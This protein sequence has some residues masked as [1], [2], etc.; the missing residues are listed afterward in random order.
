MP[1][2][3]MKGIILSGGLG[4]RL[5]PLTKVV[6]K[7]L[8][9]VYDKPMVYY[10]LTTLINA[11]IKEIAL[12]STPSA[13]PMFKEQLGDGS[14]FGISLTYIEQPEPKG[15]AQAFLLSEEFLGND[16][17]T[18]IL[19][20]N[21]FHG[22]EHI[23]SDCIQST[24][25]GCSLFGYKVKNPSAYGVA[26]VNKYGELFRVVEKPTVPDSNIAITGL[27]TYDNTVVQKAK[28]LR[29]SSRGELEISD[30]NNYYIQQKQAR[31]FTLNEGTAWLDMGTPTGLLQA[32]NYVQTIQERQG[33]QVGCPE[34][35]AFNQKFLTTEGL[36]AAWAKH[37]QT[38]Y[39]E[40]ILEFAEQE[41][42]K[43][44]E[45]IRAINFGS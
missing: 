41:K 26:T 4:T 30:L 37:R 6:S 20:D 17:V 24:I 3:F 40:F 31:L 25:E 44:D 14:D 32:S 13:L 33:I 42:G 10:P 45:S 2:I 1:F 28:A 38:E 9:P 29:P 34:V 16:S 18:L 23:I 12:I 19:G 22:A 15:I 27:Y 35:A 21:I 43:A 5:R 11:G 8:L 7:Q 36:N 39:G